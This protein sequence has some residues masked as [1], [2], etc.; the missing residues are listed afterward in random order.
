MVRSVAAAMKADGHVVALLEIF[1]LELPARGTHSETTTFTFSSN[2]TIVSSQS[3]GTQEVSR[4]KCL[5]LRR[6]A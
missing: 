6:L 1:I 5:S 2:E 3:R 4:L